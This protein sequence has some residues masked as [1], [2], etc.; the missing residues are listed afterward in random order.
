MFRNKEKGEN[1]PGYF[2]EPS[3][4]DRK[5]KIVHKK[6][7]MYFSLMSNYAKFLNHLLASKI[8]QY[9]KENIG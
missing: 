4:A 3:I 1:L 2:Y 9:M 5:T 8:Q 6:K 7:K